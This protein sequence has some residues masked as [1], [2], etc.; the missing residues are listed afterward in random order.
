MA[1]TGGEAR[2]KRVLLISNSTQYGRRYLDHVEAEL[3]DFL[4][5]IRRVLFIPYALFNRDE[6]SAKARDRLEAMGFSV[7]AIHLASDPR[8]AIEQAQAIFIGGGNTFRLLKTLYDVSALEPIRRR[9]A[10]GVPYIGSSAGSIV[11]GPSLK[12]TKDMPIVQPPSFDA[13]GLVKFQISPHYLDPDPNS[14][15][16]GETQE[17][18]ILQF[19]EENDAAVV[20]LREGGYLRL[21]RG[22]LVLKGSGGARIFRRGSKPIEVEPGRELNSVLPAVA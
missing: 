22:S 18:R 6:Y 13:L 12:T 3:R 1:P 7:D 11:A 20:G 21:E 5:K 19:L 8:E 2:D 10:A 16:M 4:A 14:T 17:E 15:H 9:V